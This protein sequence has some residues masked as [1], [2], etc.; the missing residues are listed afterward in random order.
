MDVPL[1]MK[2]S[3][4][5]RTRVL[6]QHAHRQ[7]LR[8]A[9][10]GRHEGEVLAA[11]LADVTLPPGMQHYD[12]EIL[13]KTLWAHYFK[14]P[15]AL[16]KLLE[17]F[18]PDLLKIDRPL[19]VLY[20]GAGR[21]EVLDEGRWFGLAWKYRDVSRHLPRITAVGPELANTQDWEPSP[22]A[23]MVQDLPA[24][25]TCLPGTFD[26]ALGGQGGAVTWEE[27]FDVVVMHHPGFVANAHDW[28]TDLSWGDLAVG[29]GVPIV[30]TS[31][32]A[33]DFAFDRQGLAGSGRTI[34]HAW[35]NPAAHVSPAHAS[36]DFAVLQTR[37]QWGGVLW[38][39][40]SDEEFARDGTSRGWRSAMEWFC[41]Y[42]D[43]L[44][45]GQGPLTPYLRWYYTCPMQFDDVHQHLIV[46]D[47]IRICVRTGAIEAFGQVVAPGPVALEVLALARL[48][49][50]LRRAP[51]LIAEIGGQLDMAAAARTWADRAAAQHQGDAG[52]VAD[53][54]RI[55]MFLQSRLDQLLSTLD[56][57][58]LREL[59]ASLP[60]PV[61]S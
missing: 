8:T 52:R 36:P 24:L 49:A 10:G 47:D 31:F 3:V 20:L 7:G 16:I 53:E 15:F 59:L 41:T 54:D 50:R 18:H 40:Q 42:Q 19:R 13:P 44:I 27:R 34:N 14:A 51:A 12:A 56:E 55:E 5:Q 21:D 60:G 32:D 38:S 45:L 43:P 6:E 28:W 4:H 25:T 9:P 26:Q 58:Q 30:G 22:W 11:A 46:T 1:L 29:S 2:L 17:L 48:E 23:P 35:W 33:V 39:A 37:I 61:D 57:D